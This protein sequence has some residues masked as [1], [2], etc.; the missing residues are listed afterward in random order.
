[1]R[2]RARTR[3]ADR[4]QI[5]VE[6]AAAGNPALMTSELRV[7]LADHV[8]VSRGDLIA[9]A[10]APASVADQFEA[11]VVWMGEQPMLRCRTYLMKIGTRTV[12]ATIGR[13]AG[14]S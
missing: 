12:A 2:K 7:T 5:D 14:R 9:R 11:T 6:R 1:M 3:Q 13:L 8:D 4:L 10:D